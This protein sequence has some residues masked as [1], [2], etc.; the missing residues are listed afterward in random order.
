M[1]AV[2]IYLLAVSR[3]LRNLMRTASIV[4]AAS[5]HE[6]NAPGQAEPLVDE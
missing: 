4:A 1:L 2:L 6:G 5:F 3:I